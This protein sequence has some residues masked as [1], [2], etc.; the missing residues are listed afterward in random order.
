[1]ASY[2]AKLPAVGGS[3]IISVQRS[4]VAASGTS[5]DITIAPVDMAK[6]YTT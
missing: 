1:M 2:R 6:T 5:T 4:T 3:A